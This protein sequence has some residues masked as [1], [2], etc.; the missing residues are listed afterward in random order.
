MKHYYKDSPN[1]K[2]WYP[3]TIM[4]KDGRCVGNPDE[5]LLDSEG[6]IPFE[7]GPPSL[8]TGNDPLAEDRGLNQLFIMHPECKDIVKV[9]TPGIVYHYTTWNVLFKGILS[10]ENINNGRAVLRAYSVKYMNDALEGLLIPRGI[11][12][13]EERSIEGKESV[14]VT[15]DGLQVR[16]PATENPLY[17]RRKMMQEASAIQALQKLFSVSFSKESDLLPMWN[18]YGHGGHGLSIGFD[19]C[20][21]VNQG[22]DLVDCIYDQKAIE[23]LANYIFDSYHC[24]SEHLSPTIDLSIISKDSHFE[25]EKE[26]RIPLREHYGHCCITKRNQFHPIKYDIKSGFISPYV[27]VYLP[28][29]AIKEIWIGPTNDIDLAEDSLKGWL[30][31]IGMT[32]VNI[33]KSSAPL[34]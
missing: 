27:E 7:P 29:E 5:E 9:N 1:G 34:K 4:L 26:C 6:W 14:I 17:K 22:Y 2:I 28:V 25:Y 21:I 3:G 20:H 23:T 16:C 31:S 13:A 33:K 30:D 10:S 12:K 15:K 24:N 11:T 32:W 8:Y 19:A 18:Y